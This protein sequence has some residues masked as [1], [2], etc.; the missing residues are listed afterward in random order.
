[1]KTCGP[2]TVAA[3][4]ILGLGTAH[5]QNV[6][7]GERLFRDKADCQFCHGIDGDGRGDP[8]SPG[9]AANLHN[10]H[11]N[12]EQLIEVIACG[13]PGTEMPHFDKLLRAV[14]AYASGGMKALNELSVRRNAGAIKLLEQMR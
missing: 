4:T 7:F 1:M 14:A 3:L 2:L 8:R 10:T 6:S 9:R 11:L 13:R 12:R 5:A